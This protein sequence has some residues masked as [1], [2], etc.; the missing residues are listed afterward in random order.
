MKKPVVR[1]LDVSVILFDFNYF[2]K[3]AYISQNKPKLPK[4]VIAENVK[5]DKPGGP[6]IRN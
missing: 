2:N 6:K 4:Q 3:I 5:S 1:I